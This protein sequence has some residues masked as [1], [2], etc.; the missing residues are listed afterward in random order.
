[1]A[2]CFK[3]LGHYLYNEWYY[4]LFPLSFCISNRFYM[5]LIYMV[6][7]K[8]GLVSV[9]YGVWLNKV[10]TEK[11]IC[12]CE[13]KIKK[14]YIIKTVWTKFILDFYFNLLLKVRFCKC[15]GHHGF[16]CI[17]T[18]FKC[19]Q[20]VAWSGATTM[21]YWKKAYMLHHICCSFLKTQ[22]ISSWKNKNI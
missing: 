20:I 19:L 2:L 4:S 22:H 7:I 13:L 17:Y 21:K 6:Y 1:M 11:P 5:N 10:E 16:M 12:A 18:N 3:D 14:E 9:N 15:K 8:L